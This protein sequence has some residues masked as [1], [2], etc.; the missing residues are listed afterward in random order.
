MAQP[1][2]KPGANILENEPRWI[3]LSGSSEYIVGICSPSYLSSLYGLSSTIRKSCSCASETSISRSASV[4]DS[5]EG[6]WKSGI[7]YRNFI[8]FPSAS[9]C[10]IT[11][12]YSALNASM[13]ASW[14]TPLMSARYERKDWRA[15]RYDGLDV[16][17]TSPGSTSTL[18]HTS[19][20][21]W[22]DEVICTRSTGTPQR[23]AT[24]S[25]SSGTPCVAPY[26]N[27]L[28]AYLSITSDMVLR[29][30]SK[31]KVSAEG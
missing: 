7:I 19:I 14:A 15:P 30:S 28:P 5:P 24:A 21:C 1:R 29:I 4:S 31:G 11:F 23:S 22:D 2:R 6:F 17:I 27:A 25:R 18:V 13:S 12:S 10:A 16:R 9:T 8:F 3:T 20:P 26:W